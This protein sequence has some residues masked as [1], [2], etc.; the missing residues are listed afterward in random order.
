MILEVFPVGSFQCNCIIL[1]DEESLEAVVI[2]PGDEF[3]KISKHLDAS[4]LKPIAFLHTHAHLDHVGATKKL[5]EKYNGKIYLHKEDEICYYNVK[6]QAEALGLPA[7]EISVVDHFVNDGENLSFGRIKLKFIHTPGHSPGSLCIFLENQESKIL[8]SGDTI[9]CGSIGRTDLWGGDY[10]TL[11]NS[12][13]TRLLPLPEETT[14]IPGH[15][16]D[17]KLE[18]EKR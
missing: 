16:P 15:G 1:G 5:K 10:A 12:I 14:I 17:T 2:D 8:F 9:F 11:I 13:K 6:N 3:E 4:G 7:P 18:V